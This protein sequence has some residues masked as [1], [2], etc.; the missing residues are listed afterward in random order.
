MKKAIRKVKIFD[1]RHTPDAWTYQVYH[2]VGDLDKWQ[3]E[4]GITTSASYCP[5]CGEW[6]EQSD[7]CGEWQECSS[8]ELQR[9]V[10]N[11]EALPDV[12]VEIRAVSIENAKELFDADIWEEFEYQAYIENQKAYAEMREE[13]RKAYYG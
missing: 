9:I 7:T 12:Y 6:H 5:I 3:I 1:V 13:E 4:Y 10:D 11:A 8:D 2:R